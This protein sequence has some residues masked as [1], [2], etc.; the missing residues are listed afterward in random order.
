L[1]FEDKDIWL[2]DKGKDL[3][4]E[5]KDIWLEDKDKDLWFE[6]KDIARTRTY[7]SRTRTRTCGSRTRTKIYCSRTRT[8]ICGSRTRTRTC[9][10]VLEDPR[11]HRL[12]SS[13]TTLPAVALSTVI[14]SY[15]PGMIVFGVVYLGA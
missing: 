13:T 1:W 8:K 3:W 2:E 11:G 12:L 9:K 6:D 7:G 15:P 4:F 5:D 10:L 14:Q